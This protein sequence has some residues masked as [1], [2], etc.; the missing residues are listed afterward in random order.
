VSYWAFP[1]VHCSDVDKDNATGNQKVLAPALADGTLVGY[2][3]D[4]KQSAEGLTH[5]IWWQTNS[6]LNRE[7]LH[8]NAPG[9]DSAT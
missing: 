6:V 7:I 4:A 5:E 9:S 2:G 1:R 8:A 3:D